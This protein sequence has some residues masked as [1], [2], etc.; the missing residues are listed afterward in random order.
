VRPII[1]AVMT[2]ALIACG[3]EKKEVAQLT[4]L[5]AVGLTGTCREDHV[6]DTPEN[7]AS[8]E[9][10]VSRIRD[11]KDGKV[12]F[13][14]SAHRIE[15]MDPEKIK[16]EVMHP[17]EYLPANH[18]EFLGPDKID[19]SGDQLVLKGTS[20]RGT[21]EQQANDSRV[22]GYATTCNLIVVARGKEPTEVDPWFKRIDAMVTDQPKEEP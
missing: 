2:L 18:I 5:E 10:S 12:F 3:E 7:T 4:T 8:Y 6:K 17:D 1:I 19:L 22:H 16:Y 11:D 13:Y 20:D 9:G 14:G 21:E 15:T